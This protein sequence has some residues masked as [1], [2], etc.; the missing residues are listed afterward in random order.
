MFML[1]S[2]RFLNHSYDNSTNFNDK[3]I[4]AFIG[5]CFIVL[6]TLCNESKFFPVLK[7]R[8]KIYHGVCTF[9]FTC[10]VSTWY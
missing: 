9:N 8:E 2:C 10:C 3:N 6:I 4:S 7:N 1:S 5:K